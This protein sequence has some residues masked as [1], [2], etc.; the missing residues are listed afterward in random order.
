ML[1]DEEKGGKMK[2]QRNLKVLF[3]DVTLNQITSGLRFEF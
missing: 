2:A 1:I 3:S